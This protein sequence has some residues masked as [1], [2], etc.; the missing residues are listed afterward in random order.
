M[1]KVLILITKS[2]WGGAQRYVFDVATQLPQDQFS[3][4]VMSGGHGPLITRLTE[5]GITADGSLPIGRNINFV[6]DLAACIK[7]WKILR[8]K[9]PD[10]LHVNSSKIGGLGALAGR[11]AGVP[12][13]VFTAHGWAFNEDRP[14]ASKMLIRMSYW[15]IFM[16]NHKIMA[17]SEAAARQVRNWPFVRNKI[18][19]VHNGINRSSLYSQANARHALVSIFPVLK[20]AT[21]GISD[22]NIFWVGSIAELHHIKGFDAAIRAVREC[23]TRAKG[24]YPEKKIIYTICGEGEE[25]PH[26]EKLIKEFALEEH[27]FLL[28]H[29]TDAAQYISAFDVFMLASLSEG[30]GYVM[31]EAGLAHAPVVATAVG[32]VPEVVEDMHSGILVQPRKWEELAHALMFMMDHPL[33]KKKY[34]NALKERVLVH[35]SLEKMLREIEEVYLRH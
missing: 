2:N 8:R 12:K 33:E 13:I 25:R 24:E 20:K 15:V 10:I 3:V 17:V 31:L 16:L 35:F 5:A 21:E 34:G 14:F 28:G 22:R 23:I 29:I 11:L 32:G 6:Q 9:K 19:V 30:L 26:L 7:L 18:G 1:K 27:V 4:E